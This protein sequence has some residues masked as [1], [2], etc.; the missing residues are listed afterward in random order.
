[1]KRLIGSLA[2][3]VATTA[4]LAVADDFQTIYSGK[5]P[6]AAGWLINKGGHLP[7]PNATPEG[8]NP[9]KSGGYIVMYEKP[10]KD[11]VL[12]FDYKLSPKCNSGV[13]LRVADPKDPVMTGIEIALDDTTGTTVH[14]SGAF[15][16]LVPPR[17]NAQKPA[18][19]WNHMTIT[20]RGPR[21][22]IVLNDQPV[23]SINLVEWTQPGKRPDGSNHKFR[24]VTLKDF[25]RPGH[26]G[27]QDHGQ[28]CWFQNVRLKTLD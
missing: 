1:M 14:D 20:A 21:I 2:L 9:H 25:D 12:D 4:V 3:S 8:I 26:F 6:T 11:F 15:Y 7:A 13:F 24:A 28:D 17:L 27:F 19:Q 22:D 18:G 5:T 23:S 16:D 10:A